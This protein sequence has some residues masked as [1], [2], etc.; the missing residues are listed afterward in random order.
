[1]NT[2]AEPAAF[3][4]DTA[5]ADTEEIDRYADAVRRFRAARSPRTAS[6]R[7]G[8]SRAATASASRAS[9]CCASRRRAGQLDAGP[10]RRDRRGRRDRISHARPARTSRRASRSR[11]IRSR[12]ATRRTRCA[13]LA[14]AGLTTREACDN[15]VRNMTACAMAGA[16]P[17]ERTDINQHLEHAVVLLPAQSAQPAVAAQVQDQLLRLRKRLRAGIAAR[18]RRRRDGAGRRAGLQA[19]RRRRSRPQAAR[20]DRRARVRSRARAA[21]PRWKR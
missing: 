11:S 18:P 1:M 5:L 2:L 14:R 19:A 3:Q 15:T 16:C 10:A 4:I 9:T 7:C 13:I 8:C 17:H 20:G 12:S 6:R 21:S